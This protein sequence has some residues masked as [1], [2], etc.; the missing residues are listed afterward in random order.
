MLTAEGGM[1]A[2]GRITRGETLARLAPS[3][4]GA[5]P[6]REAERIDFLLSTDLLSEGV[7]LQDASVVVHLDLPWT[8]ARLEQRVGR[9]CR[10]GAS[11]AMTSVYAIAPPVASETLLAVERRLRVKLAAAGRAVGVAGSILPPLAGYPEL[12]V[13]SAPR[14]CELLRRVLG[15][16]ISAD[17]L[18]AP[19]PPAPD[20]LIAAVDTP[21]EGAIGVIPHR[22]GMALVTWLDGGMP[23]EDLAVALDVVSLACGNDATPKPAAAQKAL[24]LMAKWSER[25]NVSSIAGV[26]LPVVASER[27]RAIRKIASIAA[28]TPR[29]RQPLLA[30]LAARARLAVSAPYGSG[31]ER[32]LGD[33]VSSNLEDEAWLRALSAFGDIHARPTGASPP[34]A[35][36]AP[37]AILLLQRED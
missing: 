12:E 35:R 22:G 31:A 29:H 7:N 8:P 32:I 23:S 3:A 30:P 17:G 16:W 10:L 18:C 5:A 6:P 26:D 14:L 19:P 28:R 2:G 1:V 15:S 36:S 24:E 9:S 37:L 11:H 34:Q 13:T 27:R 20:T 33:L 25:Q 4:S 21:R